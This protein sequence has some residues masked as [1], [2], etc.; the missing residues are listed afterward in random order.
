MSVFLFFF[1]KVKFVVPYLSYPAKKKILEY[2]KVYFKLPWNFFVSNNTF[3]YSILFILPSNKGAEITHEF[4]KK[5][6][7]PVSW[8]FKIVQIAPLACYFCTWTGWTFM[9]I[10]IK[11]KIEDHDGIVWTSTE[12]LLSIFNILKYLF[13]KWEVLIFPVLHIQNS[14][15]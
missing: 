9:N 11:G 15:E 1:K 8:K 10:T 13:V 7:P 6:D 12:I 14:G 2:I 4:R 3:K 5:M